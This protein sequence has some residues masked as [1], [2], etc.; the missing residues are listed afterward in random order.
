MRADVSNVHAA[1]KELLEL[2]VPLS[3]VRLFGGC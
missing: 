2:Q 1:G 3:L